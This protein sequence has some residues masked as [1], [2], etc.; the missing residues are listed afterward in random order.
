MDIS[1]VSKWLVSLV[2]EKKSQYINIMVVI[3]QFCCVVCG[4]LVFGIQDVNAEKV[5]WNGVIFHSK[6]VS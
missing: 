2:D 4:Q 5:H 6:L 1:S 3:S